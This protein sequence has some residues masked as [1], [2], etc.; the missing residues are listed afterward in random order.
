MV[1]MGHKLDRA[2]EAGQSLISSSRLVVMV[3]HTPIGPYD[4][5]LVFLTSFRA[6]PEYRTIE[7]MVKA[8]RPILEIL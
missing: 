2:I 3:G 7:W 5:I 1:G 8:G 6:L 4:R